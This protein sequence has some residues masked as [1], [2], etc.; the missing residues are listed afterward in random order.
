MADKETTGLDVE[1]AKRISD[2]SDKLYKQNVD[3]VLKSTDTL[4]AI[5]FTVQGPA[6]ALIPLLGLYSSPDVPS[7]TVYQ[8]LLIGGVIAAPAAIIAWVFRGKPYTRY[9]VAIAQMAMSSLIIFLSSG[10][11]ETHFHI[12]GSLAIL[13]FY[14]DWRVLFTAAVFAIA[15]H[16][17]RG[18]Y[19][20]TSIYGT[21][22]GSDLRTLEHIT[23]IV[24]ELVFLEFF[25]RQMSEEMQATAQRQAE[26]LAANRVSADLNQSMLD[27]EKDLSERNR[28]I[29]KAV[30]ELAYSTVIIMDAASQLSENATQTAAAVTETTTIAAQVRETVEVSS[31]KAKNVSEDAKNV[32]ETSQTGQK[33]TDDTTKGMQLIHEH[34]ESMAQSMIQ[35][36]NQT[37]QIGDIISTVDDLAQQSNLLAVN[38]SI[39]AS[40]AGEHGKGFSVVAQEVK[41]LAAQSKQATNRVRS[42]L[43]E[44]VQATA[45]ATISTEHG[46]KAVEA[47]GHLAQEAGDAMIKL[48]DSIK[49]A[50]QAAVQIEA[51]SQQQLHGVSQVLTAMKS[52]ESASE[53]NLNSARELEQAVSKLND[54]GQRLRQL[55]KSYQDYK[56]SFAPGLDLLDTRSFKDLLEQLEEGQSQIETPAQ[57]EHSENEP[58]KKENVAST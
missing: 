45:S 48:S 53:E 1:I 15:D 25:C 39:E 29:I 16:I 5:L 58:V 36:S 55:L 14:R 51:S 27:L 30:E 26:L 8:A 56:E 32:L 2:E 28:E 34:M 20:P 21:A 47:G 38:A 31:Q 18:L 46:S 50:A 52:V 54:L 41:N 23:W 6:T 22:V 33:A 40:R 17:V 35:L 13:A 24:F 7:H 49:R 42:I 19:W 37:R 4:F 43:N 10:R 44:I 3:A 11:I 57:K 12:F 9:F